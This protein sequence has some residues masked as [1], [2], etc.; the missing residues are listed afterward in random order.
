MNQRQTVFVVDDEPTVVKAIS[1]LLT[2]KG[3]TTR[4]YGS[5]QEFMQNYEPGTAGCLLLDLSMPE[6]TGLDLQRWLL[7]SGDQLPVLFLTGLNDI[8]EADQPMIDD[9]VDVLMKPV[10]SRTLI[11]AVEQALARDRAT[12]LRY[13]LD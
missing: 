5:A 11:N 12:R 2:A 13:S 8:Y 9:A 3:Y 4:Q 6:I 1:R 10:D 7:K